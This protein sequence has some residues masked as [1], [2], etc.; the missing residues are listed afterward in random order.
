M[1]R[2][3]KL[4]M[5]IDILEVMQNGESK[6]TRVMYDANLSR[7]ICKGI[8]NSLENQRL[9]EIK[10]ISEVRRKIDKRTKTTYS[11]TPKGQ[12]VLRYFKTANTLIDTDNMFYQIE[13]NKD[14]TRRLFEFLANVGR[15]NE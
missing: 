14:E 8:L 4:E 12:S 13:E 5:L 9:I 3:S 1:T 7:K 6:P 2:R 15:N 11:I 10:I